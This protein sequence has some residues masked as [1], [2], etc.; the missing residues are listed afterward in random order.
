MKKYFIF[1]AAV[2]VFTSLFIACGGDNNEKNNASKEA[3]PAATS[4]GTQAYK[5][6]LNTIS[7]NSYDCLTCH[8]IAEASTGPAY[9]DIANKYENTEAN[10]TTLAEKVMHGGSGNWGSVPMVPHP[11]ITEDSAKA[12]VRE[13]LALK[14]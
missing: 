13:I 7:A 11:A 12:M 4:D 3:A 1:T 14:K 9:Q 6:V 10:V 2:T 5:K 8:K